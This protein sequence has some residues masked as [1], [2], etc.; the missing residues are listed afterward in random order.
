VG[1]LFAIGL[2]FGIALPFVSRSS[3][4]SLHWPTVLL[5]LVIFVVLFAFGILRARRAAADVFPNGRYTYTISGEGI[6]EQ[7]ANTEFKMRWA[8]VRAIH[9][10][11]EHIFILGPGIGVILPKRCLE[12]H[13]PAVVLA[14]LQ[15]HHRS[16]GTGGSAR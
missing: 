10:R 11:S 2:V 14:T 6:H 8:G 4:E 1:I 15:E 16:A 12:S 13:G 3:A 5:T 7:S 9:D